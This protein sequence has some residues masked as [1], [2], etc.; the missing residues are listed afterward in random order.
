MSSSSEQSRP[1][2]DQKLALGLYLE[3]L[4]SEE[5][6]VSG[7]AVTDVADTA[8]HLLAGSETVLQPAQQE[9]E[10]GQQEFQ[11]MLFKVAGLTLAVP[12]AELNGVE[13]WHDNN[14][15]PMPGH[16]PWYLGLMQYRG[17]SVPVIDTAQLVLPEERL[18][19]L[20]GE[21]R[22]RVQ[23]VVF[24]ANGR[25]GLACDEVSE[26]ITLRPDEVRWRSSRTKRRWLA[27]TVIEQMCAIIDPPEF[28]EM[29]VTGMADMPCDKAGE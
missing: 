6:T 16:A 24:I 10:Q 2:V 5:E 17:A 22:E 11:A 18:Q 9:A 28:A 25:W 21:P 7:T 12:L 23:R 8:E 14:I 27:G 15:T 13:E 29:L 3:A 20:T 26:V 1:V 19:R 4:L